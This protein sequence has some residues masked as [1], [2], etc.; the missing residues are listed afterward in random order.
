MKIIAFVFAVLSWASANGQALKAYNGPY[1]N[2]N[3]SYQYYEDSKGER[4]L[5]GSFRYSRYYSFAT[6]KYEHTVTGN[7]S[8]G[9]RNG[10]WKTVYNSRHFG[11]LEVASASYKRGML[12]GP[13]SYTKTSVASKALLTTNTAQFYNNKQVGGFRYQSRRTPGFDTKNEL[14]TA[15]FDSTG[16]FEGALVFKYESGNL[17]FEDISQYKH[18]F[19]YSRLNRNLSTGEIH[20]VPVVVDSMTKAL[21]NK[22][23][24]TLMFRVNYAKFMFGNT[25]FV[26]RDNENMNTVRDDGNYAADRIET[27]SGQSTDTLVYRNTILHL[28]RCQPDIKFSFGSNSPIDVLDFWEGTTSEH[29]QNPFTSIALAPG[30]TKVVFEPVR[31][32]AIFEA[33]AEK[34]KQE[35][36]SM[37]EDTARRLRIEAARAKRERN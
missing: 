21:P 23:T 8:K 28:I 1:L 13:C 11:T 36:E 20:R 2:G 27:K 34:E 35:R 22:L 7:F 16:C 15:R 33:E 24:D 14:I 29:G 6:K 37:R 30:A 4:I 18:G 5:D 12:D 3:A 31:A 9:K 25:P 10:L 32:F 19:L 26:K 17:P